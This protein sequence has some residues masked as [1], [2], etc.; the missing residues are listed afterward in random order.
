LEN[1]SR[2]RREINLLIEARTPNAHDLAD[3]YAVILGQ[4]N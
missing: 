1:E 4:R 3:K 2:A